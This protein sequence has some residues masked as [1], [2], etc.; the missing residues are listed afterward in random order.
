[1]IEEEKTG[2]LPIMLKVY[3]KGKFTA[4]IH[5][6]DL[7][8][9]RF[10]LS[11]PKGFG[12]ELDATKPGRIVI[13]AGGTGLFPFCDIIDLLFKS[14]F[15]QQTNDHKTEILQANP[16]LKSDP[17]SKYCF[18]LLLA[19]NDP[20]DIHPITYQQL[21]FLS[22]HPS[23]FK[24]VLRVSKNEQALRNS[25][26]KIEFTRDYFTKRVIAESSSN[27]FSRVWICGPPK[28]CTEVASNLLSS[29]YAKN[30]FLL[31]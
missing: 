28:M 14:L 22:H 7:N 20:Q 12:L 4:K 10:Q 6:M 30:S 31:L 18:V 19:I 3:E 25:E 13:V 27:D 2:Y 15:M 9:A 26:S 5:K 8:N 17:F 24:V 23:K 16:L 29:G 1:M 21:L 11:P